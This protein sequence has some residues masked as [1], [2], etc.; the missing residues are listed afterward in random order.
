MTSSAKIPLPTTRLPRRFGR[1]MLFDMIG[2]GGM[3]EIFLARATTDLGGRRLCVVKQIIPA[4]SEHPQ[5]AEML[6]H[7][8]KL[9]ACLDHANVVT[10]YDLGRADDEL[11]I[12]MEYVEGFDLNELLRRCTKAKVPLPLEFALLVMGDVLR[13]LDYAHRRTDERGKPLGIVHRDVSPSN[14]LISFEGQAKLCDFGIAHANEELDAVGVATSGTRALQGKA[15]YMSPEHARGEPIDARADVFAVGILLWELVAGHRLYRP[16]SDKGSLLEQARRAEIPP[17]PER[18]LPGEKELY[19]IIFKA[20]S[21]KREDRYPSAGA[22]LRDL[23][24]YVGAQKLGASALKLGEWLVRKFGT[25]MVEQR[26]MRE[27]AA[28]ALEKGPPVVIT[29]LPPKLGPSSSGALPGF[30][31]PAP[32]PKGLESPPPSLQA[33]T[34]DLV[35]VTAPRDGTRAL[36]PAGRRSRLGVTLV[37][38]LVLVLVALA[39]VLSRR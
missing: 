20:L 39:V 3:A 4:F 26:R 7:E 21:P 8:A 16:D 34:I 17:L 22:M 10:V 32:V 6:T 11:Y 27:R 28:E 15:G 25:E 19:R 2:K 30:P 9:A 31:P 35:P 33:A 23:E 29:P 24:A 5:F 36:A 38:L 37:S 12:A 13:G 14:V 1:Y 18:S